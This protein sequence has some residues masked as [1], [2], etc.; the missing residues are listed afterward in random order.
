MQPSPQTLQVE[1]AAAAYLRAPQAAQVEDNV[2]PTAPEN[3]P[4]V[5]LVQIDEPV[6]P[7]YFPASQFVQIVDAAVVEYLPAQ[8]SVHTLQP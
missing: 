8:Q 3:V 7:A 6:A 4:A 1:A 2:A 5:Q